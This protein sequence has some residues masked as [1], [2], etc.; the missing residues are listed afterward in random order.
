MACT[1]PPVLPPELNVE[2]SQTVPSVLTSIR[3]LE[4]LVGTQTILLDIPIGGAIISFPH[5]TVDTLT[6]N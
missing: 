1:T 6:K 5:V 2:P 3:P 4:H